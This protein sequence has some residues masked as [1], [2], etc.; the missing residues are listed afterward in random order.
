MPFSRIEKSAA[1]SP[2]TSP[3]ISVF[4]P[5]ALWRSSPA[6]FENALEPTNENAWLPDAVVLASSCDRLILSAPCRKSRM[7]SRPSLATVL[8]PVLV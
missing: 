1:P 3:W 8:S 7:K 4:A 5:E 6:T 2:L